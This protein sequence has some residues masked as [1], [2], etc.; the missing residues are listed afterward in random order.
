MRQ[1]YEEVKV[2]ASKTAHCPI[3]GRTTRRSFTF[4]QTINPFNRWPDGQPKTRAEVTTAV[5]AQA[6]E[7]QQRTV[8]P[9][10]RCRLAAAALAN[11]TT[12]APSANPR[13]D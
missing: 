13:E 6:R 9:H 1:T 4:S 10:D 3:C 5:Q 7:W 11:E 2:T 8:D 12:R